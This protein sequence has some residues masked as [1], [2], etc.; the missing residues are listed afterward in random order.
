MSISATPCWLIQDERRRKRS[1]KFR[2]L[3]TLCD[4]VIAQTTGR[5]EE[6]TASVWLGRG[7][8]YL[9]LGLGYF[10]PF[11]W[12]PLFSNYYFFLLPL[13][14]NRKWNV[15]SKQLQVIKRLFQPNIVPVSDFAKINYNDKDHCIKVSWPSHQSLFGIELGQTLGF[16]G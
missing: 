2:H 5:P 4:T 12:G 11:F 9:Y 1:N 10:K 3:Q 6:R 13:L 16:S 7:H 8:W 14:E 15:R